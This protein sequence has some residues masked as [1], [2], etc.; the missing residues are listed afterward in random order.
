MKIWQK[1]WFVSNFQQKISIFEKAF[2][3]NF[4]FLSVIRQNIG[5][6]YP[7]LLTDPKFFDRVLFFNGDFCRCSTTESGAN[8]N[9]AGAMRA[10]ILFLFYIYSQGG[11]NPPPGPLG[12]IFFFTKQIIMKNSHKWYFRKFFLYLLH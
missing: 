8:L 1:I 6:S 2:L 5:I 3:S 4:H 12:V 11:R 7:L 10:P 9:E